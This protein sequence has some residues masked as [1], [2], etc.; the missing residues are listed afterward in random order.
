MM[1]EATAAAWLPAHPSLPLAP[2]FA[3]QFPAQQNT[4]RM[5]CARLQYVLNVETTELVQMAIRL[6]G[7]KKQTILRRQPTPLPFLFSCQR[8]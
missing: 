2:Y 8:F 4:R 7:I 1:T 5:S 3:R 6:I